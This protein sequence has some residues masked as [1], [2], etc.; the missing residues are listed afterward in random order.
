MFLKTCSEKRACN[1]LV[2]LGSNN[3]G[4]GYAVSRYSA[5]FHESDMTVG[6]PLGVRREGSTMVGIV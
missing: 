2:P 4:E 3:P 1:A 6:P 5:I